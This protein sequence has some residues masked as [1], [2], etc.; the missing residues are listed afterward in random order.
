MES[1]SQDEQIVGQAHLADLEYVPDVRQSAT[2]LPGDNMWL[3]NCIVPFSHL[4][5]YRALT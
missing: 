5:R 1:A 3:C 2:I 4:G